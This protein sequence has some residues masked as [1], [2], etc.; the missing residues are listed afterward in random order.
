MSYSAHSNFIGSS[1]V[2]EP[3]LGR[4]RI[5]RQR[6]KYLHPLVVRASPTP[7]TSPST[8]HLLCIQKPVGNHT[9]KIQD[10]T[11]IST[12][13]RKN[14]EAPRIKIRPQSITVDMDS[15][16]Q[17]QAS[18][19]LDGTE[20]VASLWVQVSRVPRT[21]KPIVFSRISGTSLQ[22]LPC[23]RRRLPKRCGRL[24]RAGLQFE[25]CATL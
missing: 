21:G 5:P 8:Q 22:I 19:G 17:S 3:S 15:Y 16:I 7:V 9:N 1:R 6:C 13:F 4:G 18:E 14:E 25:T 11:R 20:L 24:G 10:I 23:L 12:I 2:Q